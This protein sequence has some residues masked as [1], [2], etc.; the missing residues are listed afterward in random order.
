MNWRDIKVSEEN[1]SFTNNGKLL[2]NKKFEEVLKFHSPGIAPVKDKS[3]WYHINVN[4]IEINK[5]R[6]DRT[7]GFYFNRASVTIKDLWFHIDTKGE[8]IY[9][10]NYAWTGNYQE[11]LCSVRDF[12]NQY[13]HIDLEGNTVYKAKYRFVGDFKDGFACVR[14]LNGFYKHIDKYGDFINDKEFL[15]LGVFH[16]NHAIA[17]DKEG[18]HHIDKKGIELYEERYALIEPFYNG[19]AVVDTFDDLKHI[20]NE[21]GEILIRLT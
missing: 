1:N 13:F 12:N 20:I 8:R 11:N 16:K 10:E 18:W 15:D 5:E 7:F 17:K 4:G 19:F 21:K 6:Y 3:G 9:D 2:F 14:Q